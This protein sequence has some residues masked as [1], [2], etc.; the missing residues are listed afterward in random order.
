MRTEWILCS[1]CGK[2]KENLPFRYEYPDR[3]SYLY[4]LEL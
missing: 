1:A 4:L 3:D 2:E